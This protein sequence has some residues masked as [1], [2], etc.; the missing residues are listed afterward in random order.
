MLTKCFDMSK[1]GSYW[2][3]D[4]LSSVNKLARVQENGQNLV[5]NTWRVWSVTFIHHE[6][7]YRLCCFVW[8]SA[9]QCRLGLFQDSDFAGYLE[10]SKCTSGGALCI[11]GSHTFVPISL[12]CKK[13]TSV[14]HSSTEA[15]IISID[16]GLRMDC[17]PALTLWDL[18]YFIP[19]RTE[20]MDPRESHLSSQTCITRSQSSTLTIFQRTL[21]T[22]HQIQRILFQ[23]CVVCLGGQWG[24]NQNDY[25]RSKSH[26]EACF[27][28][29]QSC[30][31]LVVW[32]D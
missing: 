22:F 17:I 29:P 6:S 19:Y 10:D 15:E 9:Q 30:S 25:Q 27:T 11:F 3:L 1:F 21:I 5:T 24:S 32:Q 2:R 20:Q 4:I 18:K 28:N 8:N 14:S 31:G 26:N 16:A 23:C 12:M 13:Q 7:E